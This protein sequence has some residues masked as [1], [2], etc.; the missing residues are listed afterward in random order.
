MTSISQLEARILLNPYY[1]DEDK[2]AMKEVFK[3][4]KRYRHARDE[5]SPGYIENI[6]AEAM[7]PEDIDSVL[8]S[9]MQDRS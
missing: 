1:S 4:A 8:D 6:W 9:A 7:S 3:D 5:I 2:E